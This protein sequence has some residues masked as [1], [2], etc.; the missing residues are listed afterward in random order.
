MTITIGLVSQKGGPGK[1]TLARAVAVAFAQND[2]STKIAD[3]DLN[4]LTSTKWLQRRLSNGHLPEV[5][6]EPF[7]GVA[8]ALSKSQD[9][10]VMIFDG[11][12][13]ATRATAELAAACDLLII[14]TGL[15]I[16]DLEPAAVLAETLRAKHNTAATKIVFALNHV[17][18][19]ALELEEARTYL[20]HT[21]FQ[22]LDGHLSKRVSFS[23]AQDLGLSVLETSHKGP[24]EEAER[25]IQSV[26]QKVKELTN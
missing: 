6:V 17:G 21:R 9:Y 19:S 16:D 5:A 15:S 2:W 4:Q 12:P 10:D 24:R 18:D 1:S 23:R 20:S 14:P 25:L 3:L 7:G 22:V 8:Q 13:H 26:M 11:A